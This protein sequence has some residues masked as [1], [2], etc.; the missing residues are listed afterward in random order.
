MAVNEVGRLT[1]ENIRLAGD[2]DGREFALHFGFDFGFEGRAGELG[3]AGQGVAGVGLIGDW[4]G[5][6]GAGEGGGRE[7]LALFGGEKRHVSSRCACWISSAFWPSL[8]PEKQN[9]P[10]WAGQGHSRRYAFVQYINPWVQSIEH[11][12]YLALLLQF[13]PGRDIGPNRH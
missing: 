8:P 12:P 10:R 2:G 11:P 6:I 7:R 9:A 1:A 13:H 4:V 5:A 3:S